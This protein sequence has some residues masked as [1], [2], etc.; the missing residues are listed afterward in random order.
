ML[1]LDTWKRGGLWLP[2]FLF[3]GISNTFAVDLSND[4][5]NRIG[6][7]IFQNECASKVSCLTSWNKGEGF[8][9]LGIGHF[10]WYPADVQE[11]KKRFDE[12]FPKLLSWMQNKGVEIPIW[13]LKKQGNPWKT[14]KQFE[15]AKNTKEMALFR[16]FLWQTRDLQVDFMRNRLRNA[17]PKILSHTSQKKRAHIQQQFQSVAASPMG[18]YALMDYVNF[19]GEGIKLSERYQGQGWGLLQVLEHMKSE[20]PGLSAIQAFSASATFALTQRVDL[21]PPLRHEVRWLPGWKKRIKSYEY[22]ATNM[23]RNLKDNRQRTKNSFK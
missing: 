11:S 18:F 20:K 16:S 10:I 7:L 2:F 19:K 9:S 3:I 23:L 13:L 21:S 6:Q 14:R 22:E 17:L 15:R 4:E 8:A 5:S 1:N 12:S